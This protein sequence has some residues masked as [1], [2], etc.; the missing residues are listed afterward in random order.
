MA[1]PIYYAQTKVAQG[2]LMRCCL[3]TIG[4]F[5]AA[6]G[7]ELARAGLPLDCHYEEAGNQRI[8]LDE[9]Y[10]WRWNAPPR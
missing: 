4:A 9:R 6:H 2:G 7:S 5:V 10:I 1:A 8:I 3:A